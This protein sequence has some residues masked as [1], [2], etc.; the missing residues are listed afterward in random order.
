MLKIPD[1]KYANVF[2][3]VNSYTLLCTVP[4]RLGGNETLR[5]AV[6]KIWPG[7]TGQNAAR[8]IKTYSSRVAP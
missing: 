8:L 5:L 4:R 1:E 2:G 6:S 7:S 3:T